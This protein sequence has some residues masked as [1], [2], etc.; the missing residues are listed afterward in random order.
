MLSVVDKYVAL[1]GLASFLFGYQLEV[2]NTTVSFFTLKFET[3]GNQYTYD[4]DAAK[5]YLPWVVS[6]VFVGAA[7]GSMLAGKITSLIGPR[8]TLI[9]AHLFSVIGTLTSIL[10]TSYPIL[11]VGR[12]IVGLCVGLITVGSP[13]FI[14]EIC[15]ASTRKRGVIHQLAI[16]LGI[17]GAV[18]PALFLNQP[19]TVPDPTYRVTTFENYYVLGMISV[20][21]VLSL[22]ALTLYFTSY[23]FDTPL[24]LMRKGKTKAAREVLCQT[25]SPMEAEEWLQ[26]YSNSKL[27][28]GNQASVSVG[29]IFSDKR[30]LTPL[31][32]GVL[33]SMGQQLSGINAFVAMSNKIFTDSGLSNDAASQA[34]TGMAVANVV[35]TFPAI[36]LID[37]LGRKPL[38]LIGTAG[39][40]LFLS[41]VPVLYFTPYHIYLPQTAVISVVGYIMFFSIA[42][43]PVLWVYLF[44]MYPPEAKA[45]CSSFA[46]AFNWIS[47]I[48][49]VYLNG[50]FSDQQW[51]IP[52]MAVFT[53]LCLSSLVFISIYVKETKGCMRSP[54]A[55]EAANEELEPLTA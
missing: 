50:V 38:L 4:C 27:Q 46:S 40:A 2:L 45:F 29:T 42:Q 35:M 55:V 5:F 15:P 33:L 41:L 54:Y 48:I 51:V 52:K 3:C 11:I 47:G 44:E 43:G 31:I 34:S 13:T 8:C 10:A 1:C 20:P 14:S 24:S 19:P 16:T 22:I 39:Q 23:H 17:L 25:H 12:F 30:Y 53:V 9:T 21:A 37:T 36:F 28:S 6:M 18:I 49:V 32:I 7:T 26:E